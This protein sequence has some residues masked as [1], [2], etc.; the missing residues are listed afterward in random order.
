[1]VNQVFINRIRT[2]LVDTYGGT[3]DTE[4]LCGGVRRSGNGQG[5]SPNA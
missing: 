4:P 1:M 2:I 3:D 5:K